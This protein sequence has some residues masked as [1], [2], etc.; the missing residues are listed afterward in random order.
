MKPLGIINNNPL[1]IRFSVMNNWM[2]QTGSKRGFC[3]FDH[4]IYGWR[5]AFVLLCNYVR[6]DIDTPAKII[7]RWAPRSENDTKAYIDFVCSHFGAICTADDDG[8]NCRSISSDYAIKDYDDVCNLAFAMFRYECGKLSK[9][10]RMIAY[11]SFLAA[12]PVYGELPEWICKRH[13][14]PIHDPG[15]CK[16]TSF[17]YPSLD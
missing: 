13:N 2:G 17:K 1:N 11:S 16:W 5:A 10:D 3:T 12:E 4:M 7:E 15:S 8:P 9:S 6:R 14:Y